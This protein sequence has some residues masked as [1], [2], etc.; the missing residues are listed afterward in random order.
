LSH[1]KKR[2]LYT[3]PTTKCSTTAITSSSSSFVLVYQVKWNKSR[4]RCE[5]EASDQHGVEAEAVEQEKAQ[6]LSFD[7]AKLKRD[8]E[9]LAVG[10]L[11]SSSA[12]KQE[13]KE[14]SELFYP[15]YLT[16][17]D[18]PKD[19]NTPPAARVSIMTGRLL[20]RFLR[21]TAVRKQQLSGGRGHRGHRGG[22]GNLK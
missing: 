14:V 15:S 20:R 8:M 22:I 4:I 5:E 11:G 3:L 21:H 12:S 18:K 13:D 2:F 6:E 16:I 17:N 19:F 7:I 9:K 10:A 1:V